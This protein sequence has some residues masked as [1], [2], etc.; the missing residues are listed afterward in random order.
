MEGGDNGVAMCRC[1]AA[2]HVAAVMAVQSRQ[3]LVVDL[4]LFWARNHKLD[5]LLHIDIDELLYCPCED[6]R[7]DVRKFFASIPKGAGSVRFS[8]LEVISA[9]VCLRMA[10]TPEK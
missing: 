10:S 6:H 7:R 3:A 4:A 5:W 1:A 8:N 2:A 9:R